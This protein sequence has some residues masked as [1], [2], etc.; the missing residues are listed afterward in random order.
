[1]EAQLKAFLDVCRVSKGEPCTHTTKSTADLENG[2]Y[3]GSYYIDA[4]YLEKFWTL[5]CNH[6]RKR[7][8]AT[9]T[10]YPGPYGPLRVDF[11]FKSSLDDGL[12][13]KYNVKMLKA[14]VGMYQEE[15]RNIVPEDEFEEKLTWCIVLEKPNPRVEEGHIKDGFHFHFPHFI[16]EGWI[17]DTYLRDRISMKMVKEKIWKNAN[18]ITSPDDVIDKNMARKPWMMYGSMNYKNNKSTPYLFNRWDRTPKDEVYGHMFDHNL[19]EIHPMMMFEDEMIDMKNSVKYYLP[20]FMSIRGCQETTPITDEVRAK[21][22]LIGGKTMRKNRRQIPRK[23]SHEAVLE[24]LKTIETGEIMDM[25][26]D[27]RADNYEEWMDVGW[28]LFNIGQGCEEALDMWIQFSKRSGKY[29]EGVCEENW[30]GMG[31]KGKT[32]ASLLAMARTD[33]PNEYNAWKETNVRNLMWTSLNEEKPNEY[34]IAMVVYKMFGD[35]FVCADAKRDIWYEFR[36]H[37]WRHTDDGITLRNILAEDMK[38]EYIEFRKEIRDKIGTIEDEID[39]ASDDEKNGLIREKKTEEQRKKKCSAIITALKTC[40]FHNKVMKMSKLK[41]YDKEFLTKIDENRMLLGCEN[42]VID[43]ETGTFRDGRPD[44]YVT[45]STG[46]YYQ[47][48]NPNDEEVRELEDCLMKIYPNENRRKYFEDFM[49]SCLQGGNIHKRFLIMTGESDGGKSA[50]VSLLELVFGSGAEGYF[51]KFG[52]ELMVGGTNSNSSSSARPELARVRGKRIMGAQEITHEEKVN[53]GFVKEATGNDSYY[54]RGLYEKGT[55]IRPMFTLLMQCLAE[56][57]FVS[58][59]SGIS[60]PIEQLKKNPNLLSWGKDEDGLVVKDQLQFLNQGIK[61]CLKLTLLNGESITCTP[62]HRFLSSTGDWMEAKDI[63]PGETTL[64]MGVHYPQYDDIDSSDYVLGDT[65]YNLRRFEDRLKAMALCRILGYGLADGTQNNIIYLGHRLD[66]QQLVEDIY[67]L[68][69][70]RPS[71]IINGCVFQVHLPNELKRVL[72][73]LSEPQKGGRINNPM[74]L[75]EF[76]FEDDCPSYLIREVIAGLFGGDG[77]IPC[78]ERQKGCRFSPISLIASKRSEYVESLNEVFG[79]LA[80]LM[81]TRLDINAYVQ[82][83][84][85]YEEG[86]MRVLLIV[87]GDESTFSFVDKVGV[88]YCCHKAYRLTAVYHYLKHKY[89]I[90]GQNQD[91]LDQV[92][93]RDDGVSI[94]ESWE[95]LIDDQKVVYNQEKLPTYTQIRHR[96]LKGDSFTNPQINDVMKDFMDETDL[97]QFCNDGKDTTYSVNI[98][99]TSLPTYKMRV[100]AVEEVGEK[101]VYDLTVEEPYSN[102]LANGIVS[103]NCN[104]PPRIPGHDEATWS[105]IR[106]LDHE[107][108]FVKPQDKKKYPVPKTF[109]EQMRMKRFHADP[110]FSNRLPDLAS[111]LLWKLFEVY[112]R[113]KNS[114]ELLK[115]PDEVMSSTNMYKV[116]NDVYEE[117]MNERIAKEEDEEEA[118]KTFIKLSDVYQEFTDWYK[119]NHPSYTKDRIGKSIMKKELIKRLGSIKEPEDIYGFGRLN[120]WWGYKFVE[121]DEGEDDYNSLL[122]GNGE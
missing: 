51:G 76:I 75:P 18:L 41:M 89:A 61:K 11:D 10:E 19:R 107:A 113:N 102:F 120:R 94:K 30:N 1:M 91:I 67:L 33:S 16:C 63:V 47:K 15:I 114:G 12:K 38:E 13:R 117:F 93:E 23:R 121:E 70:K 46:Q 97:F 85:E 72:D 112:K 36:D 83:P 20:R 79:R 26:S 104:Q 103:H 9:V 54:V 56:G 17:Q 24:D 25:L 66:A 111:V 80:V 90:Y 69:G 4:E 40:E 14:I 100:I 118:R 27:D 87:S 22:P 95:T 49:A 77:V 64:K 96:I 48:Y 82:K 115:E 81:K 2:W 99:R 44:D 28:T 62:D 119:E 71:I 98:E 101:Q 78:V 92:K 59:P 5:Y 108:K 8:I 39:R 6:V 58:L 73:G 88:R 31:L 52:R 68:T 74:T 42:G 45:F 34:D 60:L 110:A 21:K 55:E 50:T 105:R 32:I 53:I 7:H 84:L 86:K 3:S 116:E 106:L 29:V 109:E 43:L 57:T 35:R 37:R 65:D 122:G